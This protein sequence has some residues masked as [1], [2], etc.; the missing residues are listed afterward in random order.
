MPLAFLELPPDLAAAR[1]QLAGAIAN[2]QQDF[3]NA[4]GGPNQTPTD[5]AYYQRWVAA[6]K[7]SD[8]QYRL[9]VGNQAFLLQQI[10]IN[11]E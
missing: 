1:P 11:N 2:L 4:I 3:V 8:E 7:S 6:Q 5:P 9:L 10:S